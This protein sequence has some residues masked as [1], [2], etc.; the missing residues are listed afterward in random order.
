[1][2]DATIASLS[3]VFAKMNKGVSLPAGQYT[4]D[5]VITLRVA[6]SVMKG[7]DEAYVPTISVPVKAL[8]AAL[9]ARMGATREA[10]ITML[11]DAISE[12]LEG[13]KK[14]NDT[15]TERLKD[16]E[17]AFETVNQ[18]VLA[19]LP[20]STRKGKTRADVTL[21]VVPAAASVVIP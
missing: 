20:P 4:V 6:G 8:A 9:L 14:A 19:N 12:A 21:A 11:V 16:V 15:I 5:E 7:E 3:A 17:E 18:R 13:G 10:S 2:N 1:M